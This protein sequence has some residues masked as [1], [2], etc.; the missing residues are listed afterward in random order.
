MQGISP[1][2]KRKG[3]PTKHSR[4][5]GSAV[6]T[7]ASGSK[8]PPSLPASEYR[9]SSKSSKWSSG[10][11]AASSV[12]AFLG[13]SITTTGLGALFSSFVDESAC[14]IRALRIRRSRTLSL[15]RR[16]STSHACLLSWRCT[17]GLSIEMLLDITSRARLALL[18]RVM[19]LRTPFPP[20]FF[21]LLLLF[22]L[23]PLICF[24]NFTEDEA[25]LR[26][27]QRIWST[28]KRASL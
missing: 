19:L 22:S 8:S 27:L 3:F 2:G 12:L 7:S 18:L 16:T 21:R 23:F 25:I 1:N 15:A 9:V 14:L 24:M 13:V 10:S 6:G 5:L 20:P 4:S 11:D 17:V 28:V 26:L